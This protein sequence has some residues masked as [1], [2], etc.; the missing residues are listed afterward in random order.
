VVAV[1]LLEELCKVLLVQRRIRR[2]CWLRN[3]VIE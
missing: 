2:R 3:L 1:V